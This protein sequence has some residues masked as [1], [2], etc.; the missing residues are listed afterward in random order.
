VNDAFSSPEDRIPIPI[1]SAEQTPRVQRGARSVCTRTT[2]NAQ[3]K[4]RGLDPNSFEPIYSLGS[5]SDSTVYLYK[6][7]S[8]HLLLDHNQHVFPRLCKLQ[9]LGSPRHVAGLHQPALLG[10]VSSPTQLVSLSALLA[11]ENLH[12]RC[13][14]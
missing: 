5:Y 9:P 14:R 11:I 10:R 13:P 7:H 4:Q 8:I 3:Q 6:D 2:H 12:R 1:Q